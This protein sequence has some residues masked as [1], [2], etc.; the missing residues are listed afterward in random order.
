MDMKEEIA[1]YPNPTENILHI[2]LN[3]DQYLGANII[4]L[5]ILGEKVDEI[6]MNNINAES[7]ITHLNKGIYYVKILYKSK[8]IGMKPIV[9][10]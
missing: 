8:T 1:I 9:I 3:N 2:E 7:D 4:I 6:V 10:N 5:N